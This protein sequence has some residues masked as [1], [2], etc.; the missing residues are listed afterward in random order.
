MARQKWN[1]IDEN[2]MDLNVNGEF[3]EYVNVGLYCYC[4]TISIEKI[5]YAEGIN[6]R[7]LEAFC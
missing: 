3:L 7:Y 5:V 1:E 2:P 6:R 4:K